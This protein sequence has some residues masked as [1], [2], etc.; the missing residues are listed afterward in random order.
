MND[1][2]FEIYTENQAQ[3]QRQVLNKLDRRFPVHE[4]SK[5]A[6]LVHFQI[7]GSVPVQRWFRYREG[8]STELIKI[9]IRELNISR[10]VFDPFCGCG[11]TLLVSRWFNLQ[12]LGV[13]VN[14]IC[15]LVSKVENSYYSENDIKAIEYAIKDIEAIQPYQVK[16]ELPVEFDL[17]EKVFAKENLNAL[18]AL[19]IAIYKI[20]NPLARNFLKVAWLNIIERV[21]NVKKEGNGIKYK[22]RKRISNGYIEIPREEWEYQHFPDDRFDYVKQTFLSHARLMVDDLKHHYGSIEKCPYIFEGSCLDIEQFANMDMQLTA[23]SPPYCNCFDYFEIHKLELWLGDWVNSREELRAFRAKGLRSNTNTDLRQPIKYRNETLEQLIALFNEER[24]WSKHIPAIV[25][26]Y[27]DDMHTLLSK[28]LGLT[29]GGGYC[30]IVVGN[31]AYTGVIIPT[32]L[33]LAEIAESVGFHV[34]EIAVARH[35]TT[36]SQQ[37]K[38]LDPVKEFLRESIILL[39]R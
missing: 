10:N 29:K 3:E 33:L 36:S 20:D 16:Y 6:P 11:S 27:F 17:V 30:A 26:G 31:S 1:L 28:L 2:L 14:P 21:S 15:V 4:R 32:D 7:T 35:L 8:Y 38:G 24:L 37:K 13:D 23:F 5:F 18:L 34:K 39:K 19:K 9:L 12:S 22:H 25:R